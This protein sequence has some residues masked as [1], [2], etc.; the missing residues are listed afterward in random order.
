MSCEFCFP[1]SPSPISF[2][3]N[4]SQPQPQN[5][6]NPAHPPTKKI[7]QEEKEKKVICK[8][9]HIRNDKKEN[10]RIPNSKRKRKVSVGALQFLCRKRPLDY[11]SYGVQ[12]IPASP[13]N[14]LPPPSCCRCLPV[15]AIEL[16]KGVPLE[17]LGVRCGVTGGRC[18][19]GTPGSVLGLAICDA[20]RL[21]VCE[22]SRRRFGASL[23]LG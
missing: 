3:P 1:S 12:I 17:E 22:L 7:A 23:I 2:L 10:Q 9:M 8:T 5:P 6:T 15:L 20:P 13:S 18:G 16:S 14:G 19:S 11:E 4:P 21:R